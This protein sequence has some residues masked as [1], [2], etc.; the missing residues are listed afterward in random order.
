MYQLNSLL[1]AGRARKSEANTYIQ[2]FWNM[3]YSSNTVKSIKESFDI[4][5]HILSDNWSALL[6]RWQTESN[7]E[8][9]EVFESNSS[10]GDKNFVCYFRKSVTLGFFKCKI[11]IWRLSKCPIFRENP[12]FLNSVLPKTSV[13]HFMFQF[14]RNK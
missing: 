2:C 7:E 8:N 13:P 10:I 11:S 5:S 6:K 14:C 4:Y 1:I 3:F 9:T 12:L